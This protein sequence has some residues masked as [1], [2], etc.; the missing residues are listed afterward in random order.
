MKVYVGSDHAGFELKKEL[1]K[2]L[3]DKGHEVIECMMLEY[4]KDDDFN[5]AAEDV[6]NK[7]ANDEHGY[8]IL[9]C[10]TGIGMSIAANRHKHIR[11]ALCHTEYEA[12]LTRQHNNANVLCLGAR[13][14]GN[15]LAKSIVSKFLNTSFK[16]E[17]RYMKRIERL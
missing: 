14:L 3:A 10:G 4:D 17:D 8:G 16:N 7:L 15:E 6:I 12:E 5:D 13:V 9:I 2:F 1:T 11:A